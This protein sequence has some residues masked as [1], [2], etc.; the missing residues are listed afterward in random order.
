MLGAHAEEGAQLRLQYLQVLQQ[1]ADA[2]LRQRRVA[3]GRQ[4]E[5]GQLLVAAD[6]EQPEHD[7]PWVEALRGALED[8]VLLVLGGEGARTENPNS[9]R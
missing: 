5:V 2:S 3:R 1:E 9:V 6:V 4:R 7:L 8:L